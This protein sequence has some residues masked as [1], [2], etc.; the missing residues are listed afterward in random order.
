MR[1]RERERERGT[2]GSR[3][4]K[5]TCIDKKNFPLQTQSLLVL[6]CF[7]VFVFFYKMEILL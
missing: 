3:Y 4:Q 2:F 5:Q 1:E 7:F 6:F